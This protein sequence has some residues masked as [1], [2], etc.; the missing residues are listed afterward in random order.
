MVIEGQFNWACFPAIDT[1]DS[2]LG[3]EGVF[4][5]GIPLVSSEPLGAMVQA[6][7][8]KDPPS[9]LLLSSLFS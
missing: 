2:S 9:L 3:S 4:L 1:I 7:N 5:P 6:A 8:P